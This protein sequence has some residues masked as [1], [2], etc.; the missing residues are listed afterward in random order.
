[1]RWRRK[2][3]RLLSAL[4][5][6]IFHVLSPARPAICKNKNDSDLP[7]MSCLKLHSYHVPGTFFF[8]P[9]LEAHTH[10]RPMAGKTNS[11]VALGWVGLGLVVLDRVGLC[12]VGWG[13]I[14]LTTVTH[15]QQC[16]LPLIA[17]DTAFFCLLFWTRASSMFCSCVFFFFFAGIIAQVAKRGCR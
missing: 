4:A 14:G 5:G 11:W 9:F 7:K 3:E 2:N 10:K 16:E 1:M 6:P 15:I 17:R 13:W 8:Q 12:C